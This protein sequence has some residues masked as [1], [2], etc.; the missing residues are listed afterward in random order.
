[1]LRQSQTHTHY[2]SFVKNELFPFLKN[3][4]DWVAAYTPLIAKLWLFNLDPARAILTPL[5]AP[6]GA[7]AWDPLKLV[8]ALVAMTHLRIP[9][10][11]RLVRR[12]RIDPLLR[13]LCEFDPHSPATPGVGTFYDFF[14]R[15]WLGDG[16]ARPVVRRRRQRPRNPGAGQKLR[17]KHPGVLARL[18][19][20]MQQGR[21]PTRRP[22]LVLQLLLAR[23]CVDASAARGLIDPGRLV[24]CGDGTP[25]ASGANHRGVRVCS[26]RQNGSFHCSCPR[27]Y[28]DAQASRGWDSSRERF[29]WGRTLYELTAGHSHDLPVFLR[30]G[31]AQRHDSVLGLAALYEARMLYCLRRGRRPRLYRFLP[32]SESLANQSGHPA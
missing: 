26:C 32:T 3:D 21:W 12:L 14:N 2:Q 6:N 15:L 28:A 29:F 4:P 23:V 22:E 11:T 16:R 9:G 5:Y 27:R 24:F 10:V 19:Q 25:L 20:R 8:R 31:N 1:M 18:A 7:P 30:L 17:P 13:L